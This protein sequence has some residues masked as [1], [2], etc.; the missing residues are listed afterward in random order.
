MFRRKEVEKI[1]EIPARRIQFYSESGLLH[2]AE[3]S[4]GRGRERRYTKENILELLIIKELAK[5]RVE[6]AEIKRIMIEL[7]GKLWPDFFK[8]DSGKKRHTERFITIFDDGRVSYGAVNRRYQTTF[9]KSTGAGK[10]D[11]VSVL[12]VNVSKLAEQIQC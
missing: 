8:V 1:T 4:P 9:D 12:I 7:P 11:F 6:L 3:T 10:E 2:L 5:Y